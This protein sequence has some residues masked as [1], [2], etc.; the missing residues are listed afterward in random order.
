MRKPCVLENDAL[1]ELVDHAAADVKITSS[2]SRYISKFQQVATDAY[3]LGQAASIPCV[4]CGH[5]KES[6][7]V[8]TLAEWLRANA[9]RLHRE[10]KGESHVPSWLNLVL[11]R[12]GEQP[13]ELMEEPMETNSVEEG[14]RPVVRL[15]EFNAECHRLRQSINDAAMTEDGVRQH[16]GWIVDLLINI[17]ATV[18]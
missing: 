17:T 4:N 1:Q 12:I 2:R 13:V 16:L 7:S 3:A 11:K 15:A 18:R 10:T 14:V 6:G 8:W 5:K 9:E